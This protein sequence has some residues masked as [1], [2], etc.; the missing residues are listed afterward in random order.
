MMNNTPNRLHPASIFVLFIKTLREMALPLILALVVGRGGSYIPW[1]NNYVLLAIGLGVT[2]LFGILRWLT[3]TYTVDDGELRIKQGVLI[4]KKRYIR[5]ERIQSIN[6]SQ[7]IM[8]RLF[9]LVQVRIETAGG[10][11][12]PEVQLNAITKIEADQLRSH[13]LSKSDI[14]EDITDE[15]TKKHGETRAETIWKLSSKDLLITALTSSGIG[16]AFPVVGAIFSQ[17][18]Q[19]IPENFFQNTFGVVMTSGLVMIITII[20]SVIFVAWFLSSIATMLKY[21]NFTIRKS[22]D[23]LEISRGIL[24]KRQLTLSERR[25]TAI[26]IVDTP[27]RQ[28]FG[29]VSLFVESAGGGTKDEQLSTILLPLLHRDKLPLFLAEILP[30]FAIDTPIENIPRR[31][32]LRYM[33]R[34]VV[35]VC[36]AILPVIFLVTYGYLSMLVLPIALYVGYM[37]YRDAGYGWNDQF[38]WLRSRL[39]NRVTTLIP[40]RRIQALEC[41]QSILQKRHQLSNIKISIISSIAGKSFQVRYLDDQENNNFLEW[42]SMYTLSKNSKR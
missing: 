7:G 18:D 5:Q 36:I 11:S 12:E 6:I 25:I 19:F 32:M 24:E 23:Q 30:K 13:L 1:V 16:L 34:C 37:Q 15:E 20:V 2:L 33:I 29:Y 17:V 10:G 4:R 21:G 26:R 22:G 39:I 14:I 41:G 42:F 38:A 31:A 40:S 28:P 8:Q 3:F 35:P 9:G 27:L